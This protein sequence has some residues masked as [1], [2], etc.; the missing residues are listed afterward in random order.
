MP[1][2]NGGPASRAAEQS[3]DLPEVLGQ[4]SEPGAEL[5]E[6]TGQALCP[7]QGKSRVRRLL[8]PRTRGQR[9]TGEGT[10]GGPLFSSHPGTVCGLGPGTRQSSFPV[11]RAPRRSAGSQAAV[12]KVCYFCKPHPS[13]A[14]ALCFLPSSQERP[15]PHVRPA[16][17]SPGLAPGR[18]SC[19]CDPGSVLRPPSQPRCPLP[20]T[21]RSALTLQACKQPGASCSR[22]P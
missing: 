2:A 4:K 7:S 17:P 13:L 16:S 11:L 3:R 1:G 19:P 15:C 8:Q 18:V 21:P 5:E 6:G 20:A 10:W 14:G 12:H 9:V 22:R